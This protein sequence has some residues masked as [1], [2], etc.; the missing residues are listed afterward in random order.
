MDDAPIVRIFQ[1]F[2]NLLSDRDRFFE[3][4]PS[5][6]DAIRQRRSFDERE[7]QSTRVFG[8]YNSVNVSDVRMIERCQHFGFALE[9]SHAIAIAQERRGQYF[10]RYVT[11]ERRVACAVNLAHAT[12]T[13]Q[14]EDLVVT[15]FVAFREGHVSD[16]ASL[17]D[18]EDDLRLSH[19]AHGSLFSPKIKKTTSGFP[20]TFQTAC[21]Q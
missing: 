20:T 5:S 9:A 13:E 11:L 14:G 16:L 10:Q 12:L 4:D 21:F 19:G 15:E 2:D 17:L 18:R 8:V 6:F 1:G 3:R 7:H